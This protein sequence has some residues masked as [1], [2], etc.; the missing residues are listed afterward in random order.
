MC[1]QE[2]LLS[3]FLSAEIETTSGRRRRSLSVTH[4]LLSSYV[5]AY[6]LLCGRYNKTLHLNP[7]GGS[8]HTL[9]RFL[10][11]TLLQEVLSRLLPGS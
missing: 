3:E 4:F 6:A 1:R 5:F 8:N 7:P 2:I 11:P 10:S 9:V